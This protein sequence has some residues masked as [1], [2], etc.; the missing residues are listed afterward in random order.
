MSADECDPGIPFGSIIGPML[1]FE[2]LDQLTYLIRQTIL[3]PSA[4]NVSDVVK[5][6][7]AFYYLLQQVDIDTYYVG[8]DYCQTNSLPTLMVGKISTASMHVYG[9]KSVDEF[10]TVFCELHSTVNSK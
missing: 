10:T 3:E 8:R 9:R 7:H 5:A 1:R 4:D 6:I 2:H